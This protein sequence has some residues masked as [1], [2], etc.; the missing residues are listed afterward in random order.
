M[1]TAPPG[2]AAAD[3]RTARANIAGDGATDAGADGCVDR[4]ED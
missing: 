3:G 2:A 1:S 4:S